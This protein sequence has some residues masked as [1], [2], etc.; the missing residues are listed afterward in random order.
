MF[1]KFLTE[2]K[3]AQATELLLS[4]QD[5]LSDDL[6]AKMTHKTL[7]EALPHLCCIIAEDSLKI[8]AIWRLNMLNSTLAEFHTCIAP[9]YRGKVAIEIANKAKAF[10]FEETPIIKLIT[11]VPVYNFP[12]YALAKKIGMEIIGINKQSIIKDGKIYDQYI[13]GLSKGGI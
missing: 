7:M 10:V 12:A 13:F 2:A 11:H 3:L 8:A 1:I 5:A 4:E 9:D 6:T